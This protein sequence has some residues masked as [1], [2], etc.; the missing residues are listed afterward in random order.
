[1]NQHTQQLF[2]YHVWANERLFAKLDELPEKIYNTTI[3]SVFPS[4]SQTFAHMYRSD[5]L[6][7]CVL[8]EKPNEEIFPLV[9]I[10]DKEAQGK[11]VGEMRQLFAD[12]VADYRTLLQLTPDLDKSMTIEHPRYGRLDTRFSDI[13]QHVVNHGTYHRGNI[14]AMLRQ[15]G[16]PG[17]PTDFVFYLFEQQSRNNGPS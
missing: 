10:W 9:E 3:Q 7:L 5:R 1:M 12:V 4:I 13:F 14:T 17:I 6:W 16:H 8:A 2:E 11:S 15:L